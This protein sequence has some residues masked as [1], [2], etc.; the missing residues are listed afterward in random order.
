MPGVSRKHHAVLLSAVAASTAAA[1][2][3]LDHTKLLPG[4]GERND[5]FGYAV[6]I[7]NGFVAVG[8]RQDLHNGT[9]S[10]SAYVFN[11]EGVEVAKLVSDD[12]QAGDTVGES[13]AIDLG[14]VIVGAIGDDDNGDSSGSAYLFDALTGAQLHK[15]L[16]NDGAT[17]DWFGISVAIDDNLAVVGARLEDAGA[18][19]TGS[20]YVF[21]VPTG[22]QLRKLVASD[23]AAADRFGESVAIENGLVVIGAPWDDDAGSKSGSAYIFDAT[24]GAQLHKLTASD[25]ATND[26]FGTRVAIG[27]GTVAVGAPGENG[28][29]GAV[30]LYDA[31]TGAE[32]HK[33]VHGDAAAGDSLGYGVGV[34]GGLVIAGCAWNDDDGFSSGSAYLFD[35]ESGTQIHKLLPSDGESYDNFGLCGAIHNGI[36]AVG[37]RYDDDLGNDSGSAYLYDL[38]PPGPCNPA[39][40]AEPFDLLDLDD[41]TAFVDAFIAGD[42][43]ADLDGSGLLD[44]TDINLFVQSFIAGCP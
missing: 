5:L 10:G 15:L 9:R 12:A 21:D 30:Y 28:Y 23:R 39:D 8:S 4:D 20:A 38:R 26:E 42:P 22:V 13:I 7:D 32:L 11:A 6:D 40:L 27:G 25:G 35:A 16:P 34:D 19:D 2:L 43:L 3:V 33:L 18:L 41:V 29:T 31:D 14:V 44:L 17:Q 36:V 37:S 1:D 24:T